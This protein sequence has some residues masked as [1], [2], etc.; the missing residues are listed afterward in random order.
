M[1]ILVLGANGIIAMV[2]DFRLDAVRLMAN[3]L[4][5]L[6]HAW[7]AFQYCVRDNIEFRFWQFVC[8]GVGGVA[9][10]AL[11]LVSGYLMSCNMGE[12]VSKIK[13]RIRRLVVPFVAWNLVFVIFY[14]LLAGLFPRLSQRVEQFGLDS[15]WGILSKT[16]S[17]FDAPIDMPLWYLRAVFF[18]CLVSV[19]FWYGIKKIGIAVVAIVAIVSLYFSVMLGYGDKM[20]FFCPTYSIV[21]FVLGMTMAERGVSPFVIFKHPVWGVVGFMGMSL[22]GYLFI[23]DWWTYSIWKDIANVM[24]MPLLFF[25]AK[26]IPEWFTKTRFCAFLQRSSF[27][28]YGGHFLFCSC[29]L[30]VMASFIKFDSGKLTLLIALFFLGVPLMWG[31]YAVACRIRVFRMGMRLLDGTL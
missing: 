1:A 16:V 18:Y 4:V 17:L 2:R 14:I 11:F 9:M 29:V 23:C 3:Y 5:V 21:A 22:L 26:M 10:P 15:I 25:V 27:F 28:V 20:Q 7:A 19:V 31:I 13:R 8:N 30:H 6:I 12:Y 24:V